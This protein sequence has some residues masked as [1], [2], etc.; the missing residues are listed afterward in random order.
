[1]IKT[2]PEMLRECADVF[3][4]RRRQY[5]E[6]YRQFGPVMLALFPNGLTLRTI[7]DFNRFG[8]FVQNVSKMTRYASNFERGGHDESL[9]DQSVYAQM[10][11]QIDAEGR[12]LSSADREA[13]EDEGLALG[14]HYFDTDGKVKPKPAGMA[15]TPRQDINFNTPKPEGGNINLDGAKIGEWR[16]VAPAPNRH[17]EDP[18]IN[19]KC[20]ACSALKN[21]RAKD[22]TAEL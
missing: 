16:Y 6:N 12:A 14:T 22:G 10:L 1:M 18:E 17:G 9:L 13:K 7:D 4:E 5:G 15:R 8:L 3:E 21:E 11:R 19:C 2:V 20:E